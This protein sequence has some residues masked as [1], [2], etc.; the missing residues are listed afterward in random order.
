[1]S[2]HPPEGFEDGSGDVIRM[3]PDFMR[4]EE[5]YWRATGVFPIMH[6]I[7]IKAAVVSEHRWA[8]LSLYRAFDAARQNSLERLHNIDSPIPVIDLPDAFAASSRL[9]GSDYWPY[10]IEPNR[11]TLE[12]LLRYAHEQGTCHRML[13]PEEIFIYPE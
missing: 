11:V 1:M 7:A 10:G 8:A 9:F 6:V 3:I 4:L 13:R 12:T 5:E 2:A